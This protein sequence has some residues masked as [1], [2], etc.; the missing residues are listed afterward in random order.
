MLVI[1]WSTDGM[2]SKKYYLHGGDV[3]Y[4]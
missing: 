3:Y 4:E 1:V 2:G